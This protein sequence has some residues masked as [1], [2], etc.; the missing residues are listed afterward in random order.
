MA[1]IKIGALGGLGEN[2]KNMTIVEVDSRI[3]ILDCGLKYPEIDMYGVDAVVPDMSYLLEN[4]N[5]IEGI[6][7]SHGHDD[8]IGALPYLLEKINVP[9]FGTHFTIC[10]IE[11]LLTE[12]DMNIRKY[13]LYRINENKVLTFVNSSVSFFNISHSIPEAVGISINTPDG[14]I[15]YVTDFS[16]VVSN[17]FKFKTSLVLTK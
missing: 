14:S 3:F 11:D 16:F 7:I 5:R 12:R 1:N 4:V 10:L 13:R 6:F 2:G 9:V 17:A 8:H 15:V